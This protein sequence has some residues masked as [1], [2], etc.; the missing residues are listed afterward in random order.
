MNEH[1]HA[2]RV[3][4]SDAPVA[5]DPGVI[6]IGTRGSALAVAQSTTVAERVAAASGL[7]AV[8]VIVTTQGDTSR[9]P[10]SQ[11]GGTGVFVSALRDALLAGECDL[12]VH[13]LKDLPTGP[14]PG[15]VLGAVPERADARD[16]L[17]ARDGLTLAT[18]PEGAR[19]G[20]GSPRRVAQ[21]LARRPDL[22]VHDLRGNVDTRLAR[23]GA[24]LDA[25]ILA[26]AGLDRLGR[27][28]VITERFPLDEVPAAPGQGAL[29]IEV[30]ADD[31][32]RA[33]YAEALAALD[34]PQA[35]AGA[36]AERAVL[37]TLEAGCAA[38][39]GATARVEG[40]GG[41]AG[42]ARLSLRA[43]VASLDGTHRLAAE[44]AMPWAADDPDRARTSE[45]LGRAVAVRLLE[46]GAATIA[47]L[48]PLAPLGESGAG[49]T[50]SGG[51]RPGAAPSERTG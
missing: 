17:C 34:D 7:E 11:L 33:P 8:L 24:D 44:E 20:T 49:A 38:P 16:A 42:D 36:L 10:L 23:V 6:R 35:R 47:P 1:R 37:A 21:L 13:S 12:A 48:A 46:M 39:I 29:A 26:C 19:V 43:E 14:C 15:I 50:D 25:V 3:R 28:G 18:L 30:R 2:A 45:R 27:S 5:A 22:E 31:A 40:A 4:R 51:R 32:A 41:A 9:A